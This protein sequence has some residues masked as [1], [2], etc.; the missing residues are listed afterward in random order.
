MPRRAR[1]F[2]V[3][4]VTAPRRLGLPVSGRRKGSEYSR[5]NGELLLTPNRSE[6]LFERRDSA[7][8]LAA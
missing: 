7:V 5:Y 2:I 3:D 8:H 6:A 1:Q 4:I